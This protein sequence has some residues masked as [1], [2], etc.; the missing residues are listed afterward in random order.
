MYD[1]IG[2]FAS[3]YKHFQAQDQKSIGID[4]DSINIWC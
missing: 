2:E 1:C 4:S 3:N